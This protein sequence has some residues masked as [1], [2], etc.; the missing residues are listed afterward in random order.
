MRLSEPYNE[1]V[2]ACFESPAHTGD[3]AGTYT[4]RYEVVV[5]ESEHGAQLALSMGVIDGVIATMRFRVLACPHLIAAA[6]ITCA[7]Y[8]NEAVTALHAFN[9]KELMERLSVPIEKTGRMLLL[10]DAV[11]SLAQQYTNRP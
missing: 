4:D 2:R 3:L 11:T 6:E 1:E 9:L 10:E 7:E 8:E 5:Q